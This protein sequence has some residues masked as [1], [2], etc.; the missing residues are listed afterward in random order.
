MGARRQPRGDTQLRGAA[1]RGWD[2]GS[3]WTFT[4]FLGDEVAGVFGLAPYDRLNH[5]IS[6]GY[7]IRSDLAGRGLATEGAA[8]VLD[9]AFEQVGV[10]RVQLRAA[11]GNRRSRRVAEKLGFKQEGVARAA[12]RGSDGRHD[13]IQFGL[14][15]ADRRP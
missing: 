14:L 5:E 6:I 7:W 8:A 13:L 1:E 11:P 9:F 12:G 3:E 4:A 15:V 10:H 2:E